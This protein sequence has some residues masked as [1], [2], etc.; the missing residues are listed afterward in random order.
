MGSHALSEAE[1][2][3]ASGE[4]GRPRAASLVRASLAVG[5]LAA[6]LGVA[7]ASFGVPASP[8]RGDEA[9]LWL[10]AASVAHDG[11]LRFASVD[12]QRFRAAWGSE[13]ETAEPTVEGQ[14]AGSPVFS[15]DPAPAIWLAPWIAWLPRQG[16]WVG[17][18]VLVALAAI[19]A[20]VA[21]GRRLNATAAWLPLAALVGSVAVTSIFRLHPGAFVLAAAVLAG[22]LR[23]RTLLPAAQPLPELYPGPGGGVGW[24]GWLA[25][26]LE[27]ALLGLVAAHHPAL[28]ALALPLLV[29]WLRRP[30][31]LAP[32]LAL[33]VCA[34]VTIAAA[35]PAWGALAPAVE[36]A[37]FGWN[38]LYLVVGRHVGLLPFLL[39][40]LLCLALYSRR[41]GAAAAAAGALLALVLL[42]L[43]SPFDWAEAG[44]AWGSAALLPIFGA[45]WFV[46]TRPPRRW[47]LVGVALAGG[48]WLWP[49]WLQPWAPPGNLVASSPVGRYLLPLLPF[50][51][52]LGELPASCRVAASG[53]RVRAANDA[54]E[55]AADGK[56][57]RLLPGRAGEIVVE[58]PVRL[59]SLRLEAGANAPAELAVEGADQGETVLSPGGEVTFEVLLG[60]PSAR[61]SLGWTEQPAS[62]YRLGLRFPAGTPV[63]VGLRI[64][65][66]RPMPIAILVPKG[67]GPAGD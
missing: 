63:P 9:A 43:L 20:G 40:A 23:S 56:V 59:L 57:L 34:L 38:L 7:A 51:T 66:V 44:A 21:L 61:H 27:G 4:A 55:C 37:L 52:T 54:I 60:K 1:V 14:P 33:G 17:Q 26:A 53:V 39:P 30:R 58:S 12:R 64:A 10:A 13:A 11:D 31:A 32:L 35:G 18:L 6:A 25:A 47:M 3:H 46:P 15:V 8:P 45:L 65:R 50:E 28:L 49:L 22:A 19:L 24:T 2:P 67:A 41:E 29:A 42:P 62:I 16:G 48:L 5:A 36:P